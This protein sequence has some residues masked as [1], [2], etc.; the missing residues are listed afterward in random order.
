MLY[1]FLVSLIMVAGAI[2]LY[3]ALT[4]T[5]PGARVIE[6]D[7]PISGNGVDPG[8]AKFMFFY[9]SW[10]PHCHSAQE[11]WKSFKEMLK[12]QKY[13]YGGKE[14]DFEDIN[15]EGD[16]GRAALY[17]ISAYPTFKLETDTKVYEMI[18]KPSTKTFRAFLQ[19]A[20]GSEKI[21]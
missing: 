1:E 8:R 15:A 12:N 7:V 19:K 18:G 17:K 3:Y 5:P 11:P 9:T 2:L 4:G 6:Q 21:A 10:C 20:L 14:I 16:R 13:T